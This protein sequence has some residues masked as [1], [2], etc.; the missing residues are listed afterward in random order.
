MSLRAH[1]HFL[2]V[3]RFLVRGDLVVNER[4]IEIEPAVEA[5]VEQADPKVGAQF[6]RLVDPRALMIGSSFAA[7]A[8]AR[9]KSS[10][11]IS[12]T[13]GVCA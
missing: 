4:M 3:E 10:A 11:A 5:N 9:F 1:K 2:P 13:A 12:L 8:L 7:K 6:G